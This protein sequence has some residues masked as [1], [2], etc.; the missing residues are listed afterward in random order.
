MFTLRF[1]SPRFWRTSWTECWPGTPSSGR[2][3]LT[4][5]NTRSCCRAAHL[6]AWS[7]WWSNTA[8]ACPAADTFG[9]S[10]PRYPILYPDLSRRCTEI[11]TCDRN[12]LNLSQLEVSSREA[13]S[14]VAL[15]SEWPRP[16]GVAVWQTQHGARIERRT[17]GVTLRQHAASTLTPQ[18]SL[19][20]YWLPDSFQWDS[21][22]HGA[23]QPPPPHPPKLYRTMWTHT[24]GIRW[25]YGACAGG[26][27]RSLWRDGE[28]ML[29]FCTV[30]LCFEKKTGQQ[31]GWSTPQTRTCVSLH[32]QK[33]AHLARCECLNMYQTGTWKTIS[34]Y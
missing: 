28:R 1:R 3:P 10:G 25:Q 8:N 15:M 24:V 7:L 30:T 23:Y 5:W 2:V 33:E 26:A 11:G 32:G 13:V 16:D 20:F 4:C 6:S 29:T 21:T 18:F 19:S 27:S 34:I 12:L 9:A 17:L 14:D 31:P 22:Q